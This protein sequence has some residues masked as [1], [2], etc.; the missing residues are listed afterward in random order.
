M[1]TGLHIKDN[2]LHQVLHDLIGHTINTNKQITVLSGIVGSG[3]GIGPQGIQ[4]IQGLQ[5]LAGEDGISAESDF[6][7]IP[8]LITDLVPPFIFYYV[9]T[10]EIDNI[11]LVSTDG[12]IIQN[13]TLST[14]GVPVQQSPRLR[15]RSNIWNTTG[16]VDNTNDF[17]FESIP[18]SGLAPIGSFYLKSSLNGGAAF[19][20]GTWDSSGSFTAR[21]NLLST[22]TGL[23]GWSLRTIIQAPLDGQINFGPNAGFNVG[24]DVLTANILKIRNTAQNADASLTALNL[25]ASGT[26]NVTGISTQAVINSS[27]NITTTGRLAVGSGQTVQWTSRSRIQSA[28]DGTIRVDDSTALFGITFDFT[29]DAV[30]KIRNRANNADAAIIYSSYTHSGAEIDKTYQVYTPLTGTTITMNAGQ[31]RAVVNPAGLIAALTITLP[32]SPVDGQVAGFSFT[33]AVTVLTVNAP[34]GATV[35]ASPTSA[36]IDTSF[37]FIYQASSTTWFPAS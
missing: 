18:Q 5:G 12:I 16:A 15:F 30:L 1:N 25:T 8:H 26:L 11:I 21:N 35:V 37:R 32:S 34:G 22:D 23:L 33:Q 7:F 31:S 20:V 9:I 3:G 24:I 14:A 13:A 29:T 6:I 28:L 10:S 36:A 2:P 27:G 17:W 4:G 19:Q